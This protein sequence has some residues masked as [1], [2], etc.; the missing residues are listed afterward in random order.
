M[1]GEVSPA[2]MP[3][4]CADD[5]PLRFTVLSYHGRTL[6]QIERLGAS[7]DWDRVAYTMDPVS[8]LSLCYEAF[9]FA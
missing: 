9:A 3:S 7:S 2:A 4:H 6:A 8:V 1:E 5:H